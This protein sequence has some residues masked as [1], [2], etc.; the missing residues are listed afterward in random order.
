MPHLRIV[1]TMQ[2]KKNNLN[3]AIELLKTLVGEFN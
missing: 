2:F 3:E 1:A